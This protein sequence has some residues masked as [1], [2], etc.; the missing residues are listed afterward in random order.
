MKFIQIFLAILIVIGVGL[1]FTQRLWVSPLVAEIIRH[2]TAPVASGSADGSSCYE[3]QKYFA[4]EHS[5]YDS[6]GSIILVKYKTTPDEHF[7][8]SYT[9]GKGDF[10][11]NTGDPDYFLTFTDNFLLLDRGTAPY[12]R[13]LVVYD[14]RSRALVYTDEYSKPWS[15]AGDTITYWSPADTKVTTQNCPKLAEYTSEGLGTVIESEVTLD[16]ATLSKKAM[17]NSRC[18][19]TQ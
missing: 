1:L 14:L 6:P 12:P 4:I 13:E 19:A 2:E 7:P 18:S 8:C 17:G 3:T 9:V 11:I 15:G 10:E 5:L 16:L